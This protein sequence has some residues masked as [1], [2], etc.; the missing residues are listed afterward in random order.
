[1]VINMNQWDLLFYYELATMARRHS[2]R[3]GSCFPF[4]VR[5]DAMSKRTGNS[6]KSW[7]T[8]FFGEKARVVGGGLVDCYFAS[9]ES[10]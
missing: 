3:T 2:L 9:R 10:E 1:M 7:N 4:P 6:E 5:F 8:S